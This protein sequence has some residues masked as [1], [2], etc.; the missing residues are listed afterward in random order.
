MDKGELKAVSI[1]NGR[2]G[3]VM[4]EQVGLVKKGWKLLSAS[5]ETPKQEANK[6]FDD[7]TR[8]YWRSEEGTAHSIAIDLGQTETLNGFAYTPQ[9]DNSEGMIAKGNILTSNDG[10][11]WTKA[12]GFEFGNLINDPTKRFHYFKT[13]VKARY[14]KIEAAE[15]AAN[16]KNAAIAEIDLF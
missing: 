14:V 7:D 1:L 6:A 3:A 10:K 11:N 5:S 12:E 4:Q 15:I 2:K 13:P 9:K 8:S 16:G